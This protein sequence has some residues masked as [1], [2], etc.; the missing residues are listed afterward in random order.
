MT[1]PARFRQS[2]I[3]RLL[4]GA[5]AAGFEE[6]RVIIDREGQMELIAGKAASI[7]PPP[8]ELE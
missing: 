1:A 7:T 3:K 4:Q 5:R 8:V 6:V 2:D